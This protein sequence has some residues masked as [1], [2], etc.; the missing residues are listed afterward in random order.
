MTVYILLTGIR[1]CTGSIGQ[2][3]VNA[4]V[5]IVVRIAL[6][7]FF[8]CFQFCIEELRVIFG[9]RQFDTG[10]IVDKIIRFFHI[11]FAANW[12]S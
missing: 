6:G 7:Q 10:G 12:V 1:V 3:A 2:E 8:G 9:D 4:P 11:Y 5:R